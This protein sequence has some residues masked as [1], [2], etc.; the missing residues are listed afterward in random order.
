MFWFSPLLHTVPPTFP[1]QRTE[2]RARSVSPR[3]GNGPINAI[4]AKGEE[5]NA[6]RLALPRE[7]QEY[8]MHQTHA[9]PLLLLT[10]ASLKPLKCRQ[11]AE[12]TMS[13]VRGWWMV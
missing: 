12:G 13:Q 1:S 5:K 7:N 4:I 2:D 6:V 3:I 11:A 10:K 9:I 8:Y